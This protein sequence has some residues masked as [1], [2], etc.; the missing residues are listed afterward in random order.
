[1][2]VKRRFRYDPVSKE[3]REV[4]SDQRYFD[5]PAVIDD[6]SPFVSPIDGTIIKSRSHL[7]D[8]MGERNLV[9]YEDAKTQKREEDRYEAR[10]QD[11]ALREQLWEGVDRAAR[12]GRGPRQ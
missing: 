8:Y 12:T 9:P 2:G 1:M 11:T 7:R 10:R 5:A 6:V 3:M 4:F